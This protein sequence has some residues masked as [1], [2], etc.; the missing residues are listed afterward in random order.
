M[1]GGGRRKLYTWIYFVKMDILDI[2]IIPQYII[3]YDTVYPDRMAKTSQ[4][5]TPKNTY[6]VAFANSQER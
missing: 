2:Y 4:P 3:Q 6:F 1:D 5:L